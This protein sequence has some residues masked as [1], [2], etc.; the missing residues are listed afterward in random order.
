MESNIHTSTAY[1]RQS[2]REPQARTRQTVRV[3]SM[4]DLQKLRKSH[5]F[6]E[7]PPFGADGIRRIL[8]NPSEL[9][10]M[11]AHDFEDLL[12]VNKP[13]NHINLTWL[14]SFT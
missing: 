3:N 10:R 13:P 4:V 12:Q 11:T 1:S 8:S 5:R 14:I 7:I 6:Q 2:G 9:K